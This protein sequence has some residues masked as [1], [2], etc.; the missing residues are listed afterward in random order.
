M[1]IP[2]C[3][4]ATSLFEIGFGLNAVVA[5]LGE[6]VTNAKEYFLS[7]YLDALVHHAKTLD[8]KR[9]DR[10]EIHK[11]LLSGMKGYKYFLKASLALRI[12]A[13][14]T[15][16]LSA[17]T[18]VQNAT[19]GAACKIESNIII[20]YSVFALVVLPFLYYLYSASLKKVTQSAIDKTIPRAT[21]LSAAM[22]VDMELHDR[23]HAI[24]EEQV[25]LAKQLSEAV[26]LDKPM[27]NIEARIKA[28]TRELKQLQPKLERS[29][30]LV[31]EA[32]RKAVNDT[33]DS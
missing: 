24:L 32:F 7:K 13:A 22:V 15:L 12:L 20:T 9:I 28:L 6:R 31:V 3:S 23:G 26:E 27:N 33:N 17:G 5:V 2:D 11:L 29:H 14:I 10:P 16:L 30:T 19:W 25:S 21:E 18:L 1:T 8:R 4:N